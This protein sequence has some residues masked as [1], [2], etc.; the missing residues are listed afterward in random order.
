MPLAALEKD[1]EAPAEKAY[2]IDFFYEPEPREIL[3]RLLPVYVETELYRALLLTARAQAALRLEVTRSRHRLLD[4]N[5]ELLAEIA[6][7][8]VHPDREVTP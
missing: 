7:D 2:P 5:E 1:D 3:A 6:S 8:D 4:G